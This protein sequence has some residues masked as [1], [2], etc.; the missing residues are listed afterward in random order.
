MKMGMRKSILIVDDNSMNCIL[1]KHA[2]SQDYQV[3]TAR[4]GREALKFLEKEV[5]DLI[6]VDIA[7][8][9]LDGKEVVG[10]IKAHE[11]WADIPVAFL[12][13]DSDPMTGAECLR[14]GADDFITTPF[15]P[16]VMRSRVDKIIENRELRKNLELQLEQNARKAMTDALTGLYNREYIEKKLNESIRVG[17]AGTLF[18]IDLD[19]FKKINDTYGHIVGDKVLQHFAQVLQHFARKEDI[20]CRLAGDEFITF[21]TDLV[22][23]EAAARKAE[24]IIR[25]FAEKMGEIGY[26]GIVSV[27]IGAKITNGQEN[28]YELYDKADKSLYYVK[29]NGKNAYHFYG[30]CVDT[31]KEIN[32]V[33]DLEY[34]RHMMTEGLQEEKG[35]FCVAYDEFKKIYDFMLR[36]VSRYHQKVQVVLFTL[37]FSGN[38]WGKVSVDRAMESLTY[39]VSTSLRAVDTGTKYSSSQYIL[40]LMDTDMENGRMVAERVM[41]KFLESEEIASSG[42]GISYDIQTM[43]RL[44]Q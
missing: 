7:M 28:F 41:K 37:S 1:A 34:I 6:L 31:I 26:A 16:M 27:S 17:H 8:P 18:M 3:S 19:N 15:V 33:A 20:V 42:V 35:A 2:L 43:E 44:Q 23:K 22:D 5:P 9:E 24:N 10:Q 21:Y 36:F 25:T 12:T 32:T 40:I 13:S 4:S 14:C 29:N 11:E 38:Q 39:A 30:E